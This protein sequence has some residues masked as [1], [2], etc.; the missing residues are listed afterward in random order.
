[1]SEEKNVKKAKRFRDS[2]RL[3]ESDTFIYPVRNQECPGVDWSPFFS[4]ATIVT[5][6][7]DR[8]KDRMQQN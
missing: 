4:F 8:Q 5:G 3:T 6:V 2:R 1:M 7:D